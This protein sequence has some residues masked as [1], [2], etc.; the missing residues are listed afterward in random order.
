MPNLPSF[1]PLSEIILRPG[2]LLEEGDYTLHKLS[3]RAGITPNPEAE[4]QKKN[5]GVIIS[6]GRVA[7][8]TMLKVTIAWQMGDGS[9]KLESVNQMFVENAIRKG[10]LK[11]HK[12]S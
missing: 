1:N 7:P 5:A 11:H 10:R 9:I 2:D 8:M 3:T 12:V 4:K 6:V